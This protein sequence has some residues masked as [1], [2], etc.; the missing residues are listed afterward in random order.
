MEMV[1]G[2]LSMLAH[3]LP[4]KQDL[5]P[6]WAC[7]YAGI[8][9]GRRCSERP[10]HR[11]F[12]IWGPTAYTGVRAPHV[13]WRWCWHAS[14]EFSRYPQRQEV[15]S[16]CLMYG[17]TQTFLGNVKADTEHAGERGCTHQQHADL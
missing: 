5:L 17:S 14:L 16:I 3:G 15:D 1:R 7:M 9:S 2:T 13:S 10:A 4:Q 8:S 12:L 6:L 11:G